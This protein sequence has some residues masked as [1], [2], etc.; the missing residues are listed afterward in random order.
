MMR[1]ALL[2]FVPF[3]AAVSSG[4]RWSPEEIVQ[5][6]RDHPQRSY[7][8]RLI[9]D[10]GLK[11]T[12]EVGCAEGRFSQHLVDDGRPRKHYMVE[13]FL[14]ELLIERFPETIHLQKTSNTSIWQWQRNTSDGHTTAMEFFKHLS[15]DSAV[16]EG[17]PAGSVD[18]VYLDGSHSQED[19]RKEIRPFWEMLRPGGVLAGHDFCRDEDPKHWKRCPHCADAPICPLSEFQAWSKKAPKPKSQHGVVA[20]VQWFAGQEGLAIHRTTED[21][22]RESLKAG[23]IEFDKVVG[24]DGRPGRNP[25]WFIVKP[26]TTA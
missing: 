23:G 18:F 1:L 5:F 11:V 7:F 20:A 25:S 12:I 8:S 6:M 3:A 16:M 9:R 22:T 4:E 19:V 13:P 15:T 21:F 26:L 24:P 17:I 10:G 2:A 14:K